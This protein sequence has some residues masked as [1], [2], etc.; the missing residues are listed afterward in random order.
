MVSRGEAGSN[1]AELSPKL[2]SIEALCRL[3]D[4][5]VIKAVLDRG[6]ATYAAELRLMDGLIDALETFWSGDRIQLGIVCP[7]GQADAIASDLIRVPRL[8]LQVVAEDEILERCKT[9]G[10]G[11]SPVA[12]RSLVMLVAAARLGAPATLWLNETFP[13]R[14][15]SATRLLSACATLQAGLKPLRTNV[16]EEYVWRPVGFF[17]ADLAEAALVSLGSERARA[18]VAQ[19]PVDAGPDNGAFRTPQSSES[20]LNAAATAELG[21][22][23]QG[24]IDGTTPPLLRDVVTRQWIRDSF[25]SWVPQPW[26]TQDQPYLTRVIGAAKADAELVLPR[27]YATFDR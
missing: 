17:A 14:P 8:D 26:K 20:V 3:E 6:G 5:L 1:A 11:L 12:R 19:A 22:W 27:L 18:C 21:F 13:I 4:P 9:P 2:A 24:A 15:L 23:T 10:Y 25:E 7:S 16:R